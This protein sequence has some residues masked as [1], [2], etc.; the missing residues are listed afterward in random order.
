MVFRVNGLYRCLCGTP[1]KYQLMASPQK[2]LKRADHAFRMEGSRITPE[3]FEVA[4]AAVDAHPFKIQLAM[5]QYI[6][7]KLNY[8]FTHHGPIVDYDTTEISPEDVIKY[9]KSNE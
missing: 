8:A 9:L 5:L 4:A 2:P 7:E 1:R 3:D 6:S